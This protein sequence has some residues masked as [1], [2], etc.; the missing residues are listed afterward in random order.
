VKIKKCKH[1][2]YIEERT[3]TEHKLLS[4]FEFH[5]L[6]SDVTSLFTW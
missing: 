2:L 6:K 1:N 4:R 5:S 3:V